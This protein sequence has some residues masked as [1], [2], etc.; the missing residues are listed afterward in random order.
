TVLTNPINLAVYGITWFHLYSLCQFGRLFKNIPILSTCFLWWIGAVGYGIWL[1]RAYVRHKVPMV[2]WALKADGN[3]LTVSTAETDE[4]E[5]PEKTFAGEDV[6]WYIM[7]KDYCQIFLRDKTVIVLALQEIGQEEKAF[8]ELKL[9]T[10]GIRNKRGF[11]AAAGFFLAVVALYGGF[12]VARS[13][14]PYQGALSWYLEDLR[15]K[16]SVV[17]R[18]DNVYETG[19]EGILEDIRMEIDLP[20]TLCLATSFNLHFAPNGKVLSLDTMLCGFDENGNFVD[21]YLISYPSGHSRKISIWLHGVTT[22]DRYDANKD[23]Q[24]LIEAVSAMPLEE[25]VEEWSGESCFG[26]L[27]YGTREW[28]SQEGIRYLNRLGEYRMPSDDEYYFTGYSIS[29]FC[30]ENEAVTPVRYL[31]MG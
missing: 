26:I 12:L 27:Y 18:H 25:T 13:A 22:A 30:P 1:W 17:L 6:K 10:V 20:E 3:M 24:P 14:I 11:K 9:S 31:Y 29:V 7:R 23:L 19:I 28:H 8:L 16:R 21:S 5:G 2:F 4:G 15:D